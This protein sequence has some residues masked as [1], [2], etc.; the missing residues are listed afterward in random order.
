MKRAVAP[1]RETVPVTAFAPFMSLNEAM[2]TV[3][4]STVSLNVAV[5]AAL[6][7]TPDWLLTGLVELTEGGVV[8]AAA[9]VV[10]VQLLFAVMALP[11][12][13][14]TPVVTVA[15]YAVLYASGPDGWNVAVLP[16]RET[17]PGMTSP[18]LFNVNVP[19]VKVAAFIGSLKVAE[20]VV[21]TATPVWLPAG[22]VVVTDGGVTSGDEPVVNVQV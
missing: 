19:D 22:L 5:T 21:F 13:S 18:P 1:L 17:V 8:S 11:A 2:V 16:L 12:A 15:V 9:P 6:T 4:A 14:F 20:T 10:K 3:A 7:G